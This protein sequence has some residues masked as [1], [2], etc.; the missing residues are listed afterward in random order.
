[1]KLGFDVDGITC[2]MAQSMVDLI[3]ERYNL[4]Y[5]VDVFED[6]NIKNNNYVDDPDT[7]AEI[8]LAMREEVIENIDGLIDLPV[9]EEAVEALKK[10]S[11]QHSIHHITSR[12]VDQT[13]ATIDWLRKNYVPFDTVHVVGGTGTGKGRLGR[14]LNLDFYM[15]DCDWHLKSM[16]R[17][18]NRWRKGLGLF[19][20]PW[21][22]NIPID[23]TMTRF[24]DWKSIIR[25]LGIQKR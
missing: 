2:N 9:Y 14:T 6:H 19:T 15:D 12:H 23:Y 25:H 11:R 3:N 24:D 18:K 22:A 10:L 20:R 7:N 16:Y 1:M 4:N 5:G 21:N 13:Q 17:Y 8:V